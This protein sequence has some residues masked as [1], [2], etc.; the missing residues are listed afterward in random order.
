MSEAIVIQEQKKRI[1]ELE[2]K[3]E[4]TE[5]DLADYQFNYPTIKDLEQE[6]AE[7][8]ELKKKKEEI[9]IMT[10]FCKTCK[11]MHKDQLTK[12]KEIIKELYEG[13]DKLYLSGLSAKQ[14]AFIEQLQDK[15]EQFLKE[16]EK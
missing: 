16:I 8:K 6:N 5:K 9:E 10:N 11:K 3:L 15:T 4:Q 13:L 7:L 12:V 14:I 2:Q 1:K